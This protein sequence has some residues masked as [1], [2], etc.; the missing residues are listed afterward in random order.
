MDWSNM[1][2]LKYTVFLLY[3]P[4]SEVLIKKFQVYDVI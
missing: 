1:E 4:K 3:I 2:Y